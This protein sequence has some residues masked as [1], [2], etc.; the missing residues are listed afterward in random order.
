MLKRVTRVPE[1][2][3]SSINY[4]VVYYI[5]IVCFG[6]ATNLLSDL[7]HTS[8]LGNPLYKGNLDLLDRF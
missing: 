1:I 4:E 8:S 5:S 6:F 7:Q 3:Y 2:K